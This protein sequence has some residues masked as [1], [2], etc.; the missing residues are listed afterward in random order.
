M[1]AVALLLAAFALRVHLLAEADIWWDEGL[2]VWAIRQGLSA[3]V[4]WTAGDVHPPLFFASLWA[5]LHLVGDS[6]FALRLGVALVGVVVTALAWPLGRRLGGPWGGA[7]AVAAVGTSRF[8]VWWSMELRM[9]TLAAAAVMLATL[10]AVR[11][12]DTRRWRD[13]ALYA[14]GA[15]AALWTVYLAGAALVALNMWVGWVLLRRGDLGRRKAAMRQGPKALTPRPPPSPHRAKGPAET[16]WNRLGEGEVASPGEVGW[17]DV[18][19]WSAA[20]VAV[21]VAFAPWAIYAGGR[22]SSWR[23]VAEGPSA[24]FVARLWLTL[25]A[26]GVSTDIDAVTPWVIA[27]AAALLLALIF[28]ATFADRSRDSL[29]RQYDLP[30]P[31]TN[32]QGPHRALGAVGRRRRSGGEGFRRPASLL[33]AFLVIPPICIWAITQPRSLFYS[34]NVEAR[35]FVPFAAPALTVAAALIARVAARRRGAWAIAALLIVPSLWHLPG[36]Y[37]PRRATDTLPTMTLAIWSEAEPGDVVV[38]VSGNRYP[39]WLYHYDREWVQPLRTPRYE[40]P[41]D[42]PPKWS[43]RPPVVLFPDRGSEPLSAHADWQSKLDGIVDNH[44]RVWLVEYGRDLQ[45]PKDEVEAWLAGRMTRVLSEG[46]G[47]DA[48]HLFAKDARGPVVTGLSARW[49]GTAWT[50]TDSELYM[51]EGTYVEGQLMPLMGAPARRAIAGDHLN[52]VLFMKATSSWPSATDREQSCSQQLVLYASDSTTPVQHGPNLKHPRQAGRWRASIDV[53]PLTPGS[54]TRLIN[55]VWCGRLSFGW[56]TN[57]RIDAPPVARAAYHDWDAQMGLARTL[58][59]SIRFVGSDWTVWLNSIG[60]ESWSRPRDW[61]IGRPSERVALSPGERL[62]V[63]IGWGIR[64]MRQADERR[65]NNGAAGT[66]D[67]NASQ[68]N[69]VVF[70]HLIGPPHADGSIVW[71]GS[72]GVPSSGSGTWLSGT[73]FD[74]HVITVDPAAPS[75]HYRLEIGLY[76][77]QTGVRKSVAAPPELAHFIDPSQHRLLFG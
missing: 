45:D 55:R 49:P 76:D 10:G 42:A 23:A 36:Y 52:S 35:Y 38:L 48:L 31:Q 74:R 61:A 75:G 34:P 13:L 6:A 26:T 32:P 44:K 9:Y 47:A 58:S 37:A 19:A 15:A 53:T 50:D 21:L 57:V 25:L 17:R 8:M 33:F 27:F 18:G 24:A 22:M 63:D 11:W 43:A 14:L 5:W 64:D 12:L 46:Y 41:V 28:A 20:Q 1:A 70:V 60:L 2:A 69:P 29:P 3:A 59:S 54:N 68:S 40:F 66:A 73:G 65:R 39:L 67:T 62:L 30:L 7:L 72:D 16:P 56:P 4:R 51:Q 77:P 71:G